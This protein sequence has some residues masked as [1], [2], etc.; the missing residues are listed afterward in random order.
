MIDHSRFAAYHQLADKR[1]FA[2]GSHFSPSIVT[3]LGGRG[4]MET[5]R[6]YF[7]VNGYYLFA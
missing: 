1:Y 5:V 6:W 3:V 7:L 4:H 2:R